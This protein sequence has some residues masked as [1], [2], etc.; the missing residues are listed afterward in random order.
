MYMYI[1]SISD[2]RP[3]YILRLGDMDVK[4]LMKAVGEEN[5]LKHVSFNSLTT[6]DENSCK[7]RKS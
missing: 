2:G 7:Q 5:L 3:M 4:G 6:S 1:F